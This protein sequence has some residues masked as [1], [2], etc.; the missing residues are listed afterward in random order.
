MDTFE[1]E[2]DLRNNEELHI[3]QEKITA[4]DEKV[5]LYEIKQISK[6]LGTD[7]SVAYN[8]FAKGMKPQIRCTDQITIMNQLSGP[9]PFAAKIK[10]RKKKFQKLLIDFKNYLVIPYF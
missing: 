6:G 5:P 3:K 10:K 9:A 4:V 8:N 7:V 1:V 2:L